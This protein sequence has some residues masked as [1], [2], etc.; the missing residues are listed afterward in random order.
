MEYQSSAHR[1]VVGTFAVIAAA[2]AI[3]LASVLI[4]LVA[5]TG[6]RSE[7]MY[8]LV[9]SLACSF[10]VFFAVIAVQAT[11]FV[12][13]PRAELMPVGRW[14]VLS[15]SLALIGVAGAVVFHWVAILFPLTIALFCLL[16]E[17]RVEAW[18]RTLGV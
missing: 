10:T 13:K 2:I 5:R 17:P 12:R 15:A 18:I 8:G 9:L 7:P 11:S 3:A 4:L 16:K 14:R 1:V 6:F